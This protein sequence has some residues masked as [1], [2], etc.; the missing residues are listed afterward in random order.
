MKFNK[1]FMKK[2][3]LPSC[4][5]ATVPMD[6]ADPGW[7]PCLKENCWWE[8]SNLESGRAAKMGSLTGTELSDFRLLH[9]I[10]IAIGG[11]ETCFPDIEEDM[12]KI[13]ERGRFYKG[14][15][16][17]IKGRPSRCHENACLLWRRNHASHDI[18]IATGYALSKDGMW[19]QH[20][21]L[22]QRY[23]TAKQQRTRIIETTK[24]RVAYFGFEMTEEEAER[25]CY[26][27][28]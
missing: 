24:K 22:V 14:T 11:E 12:T 6:E 15:S 5:I 28:C 4:R 13:L 18:H 3:N 19:R 7:R 17:M 2:H 1:E 10:L 26:Y 23:S 8:S 9:D 16:K 20:S 25:F 21:W 27:N